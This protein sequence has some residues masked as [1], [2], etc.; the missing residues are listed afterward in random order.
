MQWRLCFSGMF[1]GRWVASRV[2]EDLNVGI[3]VWDVAKTKAARMNA[4]VATVRTRPYLRTSPG[5]ACTR[6]LA[7]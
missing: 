6:Q 5:S 3:Q 4:R 1:C 7:R 2:V